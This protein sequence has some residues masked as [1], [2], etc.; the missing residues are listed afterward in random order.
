MTSAKKYT[1][2]FP[3]LLSFPCNR[4]QALMD[5]LG[6]LTAPP[7]PRAVL[8]TELQE[9]HFVPLVGVCTDQGRYLKENLAEHPK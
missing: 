8:P 4:M 5:G 6:L 3:N 2:I 7:I 1:F 9:V